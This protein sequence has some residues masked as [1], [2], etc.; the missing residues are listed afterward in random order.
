MEEGRPTWPL[1]Q[2]GKPGAV[3]SGNIVVAVAGRSAKRIAA[4]RHRPQI[5]GMSKLPETIAV[6]V[7][8]THLPANWEGHPVYLAVQKARAVEQCVPGSAGKATFHLS[9]RV[10]EADGTPNFLGPYAQGTRD[11]RFFYLSWGISDS[12]ASFGMF[13]RLKVHLSHLTGRDLL[14]AAK[15]DRPLRVTL[16]MQDARGG[17]RCASVWPDDPG[18]TWQ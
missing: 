13:R 8:C 17:P 3:G 16:Q 6:E 10:A 1:F 11:E 7:R 2:S 18:V 15:A 9:F 12:P 14:A 5:G 4:T